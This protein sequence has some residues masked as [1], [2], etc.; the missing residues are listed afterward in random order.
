MLLLVSSCLFPDLGGLSGDDAGGPD[1]ATAD[2]TK[3]DGANDVT[4]DTSDATFDVGPPSDAGLDV[5][6][7][8]CAVK[9]TFCD[10]FDN[11]SLGATWDKTD[12]GGGGTL[13][14]SANAV[15]P[16]YSF[17][18]QVP[19]GGGHPYALLQKVLNASQHVHYECDIMIIGSQASQMEVDYYDIAF[20]PTGYTYGNFNLERLNTGG[21]V[22]EI[23]HATTADADT[24]NDDSISEELTTWKHIVVDI[25]YTK[26]TFTLSVDGATIDAMSMKPPLASAQSTLGVGITYTGGLSATWTVLIDNV[27]IDLQ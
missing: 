1:D 4:P 2:V 21:T 19:G 22:E 24:Y 18:A 12:N 6:T 14:Q 10:D 5:K 13:S 9:H 11:G 7:S 16:P 26:S 23:A 17:Q 20:V 3:A 8:P 25:D 15:T 27:V